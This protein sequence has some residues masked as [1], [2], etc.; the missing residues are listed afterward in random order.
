MCRKIKQYRKEMVM[1]LKC[2]IVTNPTSRMR[3]NVENNG[4]NITMKM[5][6]T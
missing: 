1:Q 2:H 5:M 6:H 4:A 3:A